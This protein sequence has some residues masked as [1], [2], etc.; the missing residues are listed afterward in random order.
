M[1]PSRN[2]VQTLLVAAEL[3]KQVSLQL[4][5]TG[6]D[7]EDSWVVLSLAARIAERAVIEADRQ[8]HDL[9]AYAAAKSRLAHLESISDRI[10]E[11]TEVEMA[12][13]D[14]APD[15]IRS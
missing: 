11:A 13:A 1:K 6:Q 4:T 8:A 3:A 7:A 12:A 14:G 2:D 15:V 9:G 10:S 5:T